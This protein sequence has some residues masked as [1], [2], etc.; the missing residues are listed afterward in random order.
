MLYGSNVSSKELNHHGL[1]AAV[2][3]DLGLVELINKSIKDESLNIY[4][5]PLLFPCSTN[6]IKNKIIT[7]VYFL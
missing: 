7:Y 4:I 3:E 2:I 6:N 1:V 5:S